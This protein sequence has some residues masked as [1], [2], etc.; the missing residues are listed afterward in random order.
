M[1]SI[2]VIENKTN[3]KLYVGQT[4]DFSQRVR[5]HKSALKNHSGN[6]H[7]LQRAVDKYG[8]DQFDF[9]EIAYA[10]TIEELNELEI[11]FIRLFDSVKNGYNIKYG[12]ENGGKLP[13]ESRKLISRRLKELYRIS[14]HP[15][16]GKKHSEA[17]RKRISQA[18]MGKRMDEAFCQ[19]R[20]ELT[21]GENNPM[22]GKSHSEETKRKIGEANAGKKMPPRSEEYRQAVFERCAQTY[23]VT[24]P[25]GQ[26][27]VITGLAKYC[28]ENGLT[29]SAASLVASGKRPHHKGYVFRKLYA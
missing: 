16:I 24:T 5:A 28:R 25:E 11:L 23:E 9:Y 15:M 7:K 2:Y 20:S 22:F 8:L 4:I 18:H 26:H 3:G 1:F 29:Q 27:L 10:A 17:T 19:R 14:P 12:G 21:S 13:E 6:N